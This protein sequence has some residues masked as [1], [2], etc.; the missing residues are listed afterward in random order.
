M[1][2][3]TGDD[4]ADIE[5]TLDLLSLL[6]DPTRLEMLLT[7]G[8]A[9]QPRGSEAFTFSDFRDAVEIQDSGRFNYHLSQLRGTFIEETEDGYRPTYPGLVLYKLIR[10]GALTTSEMAPPADTGV[11]CLEC[12]AMVE[13][14]YDAQLLTLRCP[15]CETTYTRIHVPPG[16]VADTDGPHRFRAA[17][18]YTFREVLPLTHGICPNCGGSA[19]HDVLDPDEHRS[20]TEL[21]T[22]VHSCHE[23]NYWMQT[24]FGIPIALD[25][26]V[27]AAFHDHGIDLLSGRTNH[28]LRFMQSEALSVLSRDPWSVEISIP[29]AG[30]TVS[31]EVDETLTVKDISSSESAT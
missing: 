27:I 5:E 15:A 30:E 16:C 2:A 12:A 11:E 6:D 10:S 17:I 18:Q 7:L 24:S 25:P 21:P 22:V 28:I 3:G 14:A 19:T 20:D 9:T 13:A 8:E 4:T 29:L 23:C 31:I 26:G 1:T